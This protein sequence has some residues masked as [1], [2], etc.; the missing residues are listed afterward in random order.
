MVIG[1]ITS[2]IILGLIYYLLFFPITFILRK[3][4]QKDAPDEPG[5]HSREKDIIDYKKLY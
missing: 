1:E 2:V 4:R 5:W 3:T